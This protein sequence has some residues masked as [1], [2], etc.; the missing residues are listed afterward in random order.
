M[1]EYNADLKIY[2]G[3]DWDT[4]KPKTAAENVSFSDSDVKTV[5]ET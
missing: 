1:A 4:Y 2:N 5:L 3:E